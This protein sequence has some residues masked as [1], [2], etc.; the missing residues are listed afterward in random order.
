MER[1][2][3]LIQD[4]SY[5]FS[6]GVLKISII[7]TYLNKVNQTFLRTLKLCK[8]IDKEIAC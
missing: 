2:A 4:T 6:Y 1:F 5:L 8:I 3:F 7:D